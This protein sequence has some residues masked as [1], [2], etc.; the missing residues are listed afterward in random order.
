MV[1]ETQ[2]TIARLVVR[3]YEET[4]KFRLDSP[5]CEKENIRIL[6]AFA[7]SRDW[8]VHSLDVKAAFLQGKGIE[9]DILIIPKER[10]QNGC[11]WKMKKVVYGLNNALRSWYLRVTEAMEK[12]GLRKL[13]LNDA[14]FLWKTNGIVQVIVAVHVV[15]MLFVGTKVF[16]STIMDNIKRM[17]KISN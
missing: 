6:L 4:E 11:P 9:R 8:K 5:T 14:I 15:D 13:A 2:V 17:F 1:D 7:A 10:Q 3:G 12:Y 16:Y